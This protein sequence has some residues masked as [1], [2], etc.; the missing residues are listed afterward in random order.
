MPGPCTALSS[1]E[2]RPFARTTCATENR[3]LEATYRRTPEERGQLN[4]P[5]EAPTSQGG[6]GTAHLKHRFKGLDT[7]K[8]RSRG[9]FA[10]MANLLT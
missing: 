10:R 4:Q 1:C 6:I 5:R 3:L 8:M 9:H 7:V 2:D